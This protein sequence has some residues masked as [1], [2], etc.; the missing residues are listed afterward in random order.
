MD[1]EVSELSGRVDALRLMLIM[2]VRTLPDPS[3]A[4]VALHGLEK[5][6]RVQNAA[7][8]TIEEVVEVRAALDD[9]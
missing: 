4:M 5:A 1:D 2:V 9:L 6:L 3:A 8:S 7:A